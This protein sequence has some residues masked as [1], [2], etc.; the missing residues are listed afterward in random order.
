[1][2]RFCNTCAAKE[3]ERA[4]KDGWKEIS[5]ALYSLALPRMSSCL[6]CKTQSNGFT[7][8][9]GCAI[10][11]MECQDC[12]VAVTGANQCLRAEVIGHRQTL[13][14]ART[15]ADA[16]YAQ[17]IAPFTDDVAK[18]AAA[19][20]A[21]EKQ[22]E[23]ESEP[24]WEATRVAHEAYQALDQKA[25]E[26]VRNAAWTAY[27]DARKAQEKA[28]PEAYE[29]HRERHRA[30]IQEF[31]RHQE[32]EAAKKL[33]DNTRLRVSGLFTAEVDRSF[34][35]AEANEAHQAAL[36]RVEERYQ[37]ALSFQKSL[38]RMSNINFI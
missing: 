21:S 6:I 2:T 26:S 38:D 36:T 34:G 27:M 33:L 25:E 1:M 23:T 30:L 15:A 32:Y 24:L 11:R 14:A 4:K 29:R 3:R 22:I 18:F 37:R 17:T 19:L 9:L 8:C 7:L 16:L 20:A 5:P 28:A 13:N 10:E 12:T 31:P 35:I